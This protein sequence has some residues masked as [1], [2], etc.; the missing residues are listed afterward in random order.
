MIAGHPYLMLDMGRAGRR[1]PVPRHGVEALWGGSTPLD[2]RYLT[3]YM[4]DVSV[5]TDADYRRLHPP[6]ALTSFPTDLA[7]PD[8]QYSGIYEDGWASER[9]YAILGGGPAANL[10]VEGDVP[11]GGGGRL[12]VLLDGR[13]IAVEMLEPGSFTVRVAAPASRAP[14]R[15]DMRFSSAPPLPEP[16]G[17]PAAAHL[18]YVGFESSRG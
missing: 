6:R 2:P 11:Q 14:R 7:N 10:V 4:R 15:V 8:L 13:S 9:A 1:P 16:D 12:D 18:R 3:A 5:I 17:R